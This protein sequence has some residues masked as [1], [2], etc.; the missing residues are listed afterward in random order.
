VSKH[1]WD[2]EVEVSPDLG[3]SLISRQF[4]ELAPISIEQLGFGWDNIAYLVNGEFVFRFPRRSIAAPLISTEA[5]VL[6]LIAR[7]LP[8]Q[9]PIPQF[10][11]E[12]NADYPWNFVGYRRIGGTVASRLR[13]TREVRALLAK[14]LA[15]CLKS[16]H[17]IDPGTARANG[18]G[19]DVMGRFDAPKR[20]PIAKKRI[21][22]LEAAGAIPD[23]TPLLDYMVHNE[24]GIAERRVI[25]HGDLYADHILLDENGAISGLIDWGD[26]HFGDP[27]LDLACAHSMLPPESHGTFRTAYGS[28]DESTWTRARW[29]AIYAAVM[30]LWYA[31]K[32]ENEDLRFWGLTALGYLNEACRSDRATPKSPPLPN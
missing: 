27:A 3:K 32:T 24:P 14:P 26:V 4:P 2:P 15:T 18:L 29:R 11:G 13:L 28:I 12:P 19:P 30:I 25:V 21:L 17:A 31:V 16:L 6:P 7:K 22:D 8:V 20:Y 1:E 23:G 10:I 9:I 5:R